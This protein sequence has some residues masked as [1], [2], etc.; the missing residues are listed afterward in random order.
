MK[1][2]PA[3]LLILL[4]CGLSPVIATAKK[5]PDPTD[6]TMI[7]IRE[8]GCR[9]C[10]SIYARGSSLATDLTEV[11]TR[12]T[13]AQIAAFLADQSPTRTKKFMP[14]Y[15]SLTDAERQQISEYLYNLH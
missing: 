2:I 8:L 15:R 10:H 4:F 6:P 9:G 13:A 7:F 3:I 12:L 1:I 14:G 5:I 11:G